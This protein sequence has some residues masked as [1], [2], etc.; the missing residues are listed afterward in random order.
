MLAVILYAARAGNYED[1][2]AGADGS[3]CD[4]GCFD[5]DGEFGGGDVSRKRRPRWRHLHGTAWPCLS[6]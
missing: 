6:G 3:D 2:E 4:F 5:G 1:Y